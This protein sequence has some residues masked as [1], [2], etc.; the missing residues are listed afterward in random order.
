[1][2]Y[3]RALF[4]GPSQ[5]LGAKTRNH[6]RVNKLEVCPAGKVTGVC[7]IAKGLDRTQKYEGQNVGAQLRAGHVILE[8]RGIY[9]LI[10]KSCS[11]R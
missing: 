5:K 3:T 9:S 4:R 1:M 7:R 6:H 2:E 10:A 8:T 11:P